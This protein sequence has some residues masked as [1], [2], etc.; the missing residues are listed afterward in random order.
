M[1]N[2]EIETHDLYQIYELETKLSNLADAKEREKIINKIIIISDK[3][4]MKLDPKLSQSLY[5][6]K[7]HDIACSRS[8]ALLEKIKILKQKVIKF[9]NQ[10]EI[11]K[12]NEVKSEAAE[13]QIKFR[14][15]NLKCIEYIQ[16]C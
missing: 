8:T 9:F 2:A 10:G 3:H 7:I 15:E 12:F 11:A 5:R 16:H 13:L 14:E 1:I 6:Q 4:S